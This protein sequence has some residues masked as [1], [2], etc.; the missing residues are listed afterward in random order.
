MYFLK[1]EFFLPISGMLVLDNGAIMKPKDELY[2]SIGISLN[3]QQKGSYELNTALLP[4]SMGRATHRCLEYA[5]PLNVLIT[6]SW[7]ACHQWVQLSSF[8]VCLFQQNHNLSSGCWWCEVGIT[9]KLFKY[10]NFFGTTAVITLPLVWEVNGLFKHFN[11]TGKK[12]CLQRRCVYC[13]TLTV[14][15]SKETDRNAL[16]LD[17]NGKVSSK[18]NHK[19]LKCLQELE[20]NL[21]GVLEHYGQLFVSWPTASA[22]HSYHHSTSKEV[23]EANEPE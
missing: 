22:P 6:I 10:Q 20:E 21:L 9:Q 7:N 12:K 5:Q 15:H 13:H 14:K 16:R 1:V 18:G 17:S 23:T 19:K 8:Q 4:C 2:F 3:L 11:F